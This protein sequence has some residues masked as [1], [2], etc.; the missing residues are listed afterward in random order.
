MCVYKKKIIKHKQVEKNKYVGLLCIYMDQEVMKIAKSF[1]PAP[2]IIANMGN[3]SVLWMSQKA[4]DVLGMQESEII[5]KVAFFLSDLPLKETKKLAM[6]DT[7]VG[8]GVRELPI[9]TKKGTV[10]VIM[11][12]HV[13]EHDSIFYY[14]GEAINIKPLQKA[15]SFK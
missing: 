2:D 6:L 14:V 5:G 13:F 12:Y 11:E 7:R 3:V 15:P 8:K 1:I 10:L 4:L 9:K